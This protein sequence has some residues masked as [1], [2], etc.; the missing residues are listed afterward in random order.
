LAG[1]IS[2]YRQTVPTGSQGGL[3]YHGTQQ[4]LAFYLQDKVS[5]LPNLTLTAGLRWEGQWN[6]QSDNPN[7][8]FPATTKIPNDLNQ[9]QPRLGLAWDPKNNGKTVIRLSSGLYDARTPGILLQ[10]IFTDNNL[11]TAVL[12]SKV[13]PNLLTVVLLPNPLQK[14]PAGIKLAPPKVVGIDPNFRNPRSFQASLSIETAV[15]ENYVLSLSYTRNATWAL[16]RRFDTNLFAPTYDATGMPIFP[17]VRPNPAIGPYSINQSRSHSTYDGI[18]L[19]VERRMAKRF[20]LS[21][22]YTLA[23]NRDDDTQERVFDREPVLDPFN[24]GLENAW[25]KNDIRH[26]FRLSGTTDLPHGFSVT[27]I[28]LAHSG[29]PFTPVIG[30]DTQNDGN[31]INDRA[32]I[33]NSVAGRNSMRMDA[34]LDVDLRVQKTFRLGERSSL[35]V[36]ADFLNATNSPNKNY[37]PDSVSNYGTA[38]NPNPTAGQPLFAPLTTRFGGA[39]QMQVGARIVF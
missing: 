8:A 29:L 35:R 12:D 23:W 1:K 18:D 7:P 32:I 24:P 6:P 3:V 28:T 37:G 27:G 21:A 25:S 34:F 4:E 38:A 30:F 5:V 2:R 20:Q 22:G 19:T 36:M 10:R 31:D 17:K 33:N 16:Q 39:R 13:D 9:W 11:T 14:V 26:N 15:A